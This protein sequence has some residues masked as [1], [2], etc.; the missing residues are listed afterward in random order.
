[1]A[2]A[3]RTTNGPSARA[4]FTW[5]TRAASSLP[6]PDEPRMRMRLLVGAT[7]SSAL[8]SWLI[9]GDLPTMSA[10]KLERSRSSFTSRFSCEASS[11][12]SVTRIRRSALNGFS[13]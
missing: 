5:M 9:A 10:L 8:R 2:A 6:E 12:R 4:D 1:M 11:A 13:M 7:R 3:L